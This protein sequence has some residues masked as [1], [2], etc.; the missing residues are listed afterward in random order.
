MCSFPPRERRVVPV[1]CVEVQAVA[2]TFKKLESFEKKLLAR[3][4]TGIY[5]PRKPKL[6]VT[7]ENR[8]INFRNISFIIPHRRP[9]QDTVFRCIQ[10]VTPLTA[11]AFLSLS[12][13]RP[14]KHY[15]SVNVKREVTGIT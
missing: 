13:T 4:V 10:E 2:P 6:H 1:A 9:R 14:Q 12:T 11:G 15:V 3:K 5:G 7:T 8:T